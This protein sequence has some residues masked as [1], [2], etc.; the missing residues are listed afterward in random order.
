MYQEVCCSG[1][2][3]NFKSGILDVSGILLCISVRD[4]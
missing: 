1:L 3:G 2:S 4:I